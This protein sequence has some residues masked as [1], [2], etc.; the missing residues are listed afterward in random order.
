MFLCQPLN[1]TTPVIR[2]KEVTLKVGNFHALHTI[3]DRLTQIEVANLVSLG[4]QMNIDD[5]FLPK[6]FGIPT[7][8]KVTVDSRLLTRCT[9]RFE[10]ADISLSGSISQSSRSIY[11]DFM[12]STTFVSI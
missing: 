5:D 10:V 4:R 2:Q 3:I 8:R 1:Q 7:L 11:C 12:C 9:V 6:L